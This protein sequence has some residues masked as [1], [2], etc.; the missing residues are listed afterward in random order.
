MSNLT[1]TTT[2]TTPT[3]TA[4]LSELL[5]GLY[6]VP[7][8]EGK[9]LNAKL[10]IEKAFELARATAQDHVGQR[11]AVKA[12]DILMSRVHAKRNAAAQNPGPATNEEE[13]E[14]PVGIITRMIRRFTTQDVLRKQSNQREFLQESEVDSDDNEQQ[15]STQ[16]EQEQQQDVELTTSNTDQ[17]LEELDEETQFEEKLKQQQQSYYGT[18]QSYST[19]TLPTG[20]STDSNSPTTPLLPG[21]TNTTL[22]KNPINLNDDDDNNNKGKESP[23]ITHSNNNNDNDNPPF[24]TGTS[25]TTTKPTT[26]SAFRNSN[27]VHTFILPFSEKR[28][29]EIWQQEL[30]RVNKEYY[31]ELGKLLKRI[32]VVERRPLEPHITPTA[33]QEQTR[34]L[35][36]ELMDIYHELSRMSQFI[37]ANESLAHRLCTHESIVQ[38]KFGPRLRQQL[39]HQTNQIL[40]HEEQEH[41]TH[42][43]KIFSNRLGVSLETAKFELRRH[44]QLEE[45]EYIDGRSRVARSFALGVTI[46]SAIWSAIILIMLKAH[47]RFQKHG[48]LEIFRGFVILTLFLWSAVIQ[49]AI[50]TTCRVNFVFLFQFDDSS[51]RFLRVPLLLSIA[52][53]MTLLVI[54]SIFFS[55]M[56]LGHHEKNKLQQQQQ[57]QGIGGGQIAEINGG[58]VPILVGLVI[59]FLFASFG[60]LAMAFPAWKHIV[61]KTDKTVALQYLMGIAPPSFAA[62]YSA[63]IFTSMSKVLA[64]I[65]RG[66]CFLATP[67]D[68]NLSPNQRRC[69]NSPILHY[70]IVFL[71]LWPLWLRLV[72]NFLQ[73]VNT[74]KRFP[75]FYNMCKYIFAHQVVLFTVFRPDLVSE[76]QLSSW[77]YMFFATNSIACWMWDVWVDFGLG[78]WN[79]SG[80]RDRRMYP[81]TKFYYLA[82]VLDFVLRFSWTLSLMS[83][84][85]YSNSGTF[86][87]GVLSPL[88]LIE[89]VRRTIWCLIRVE[90]EHLN[91]TIGYRELEFVPLY[92]DE[93]FVARDKE[94]DLKP[95]NKPPGWGI[96]MYTRLLVLFFVVGILVLIT[97]EVDVGWLEGKY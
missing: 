9:Y 86:V 74:G 46:S 39:L 29:R 38:Y 69:T 70:I 1:T 41:I 92:F 64:D 21:T 96:L 63:D 84:S 65:A 66:L 85:S 27:L 44:A 10:L 30:L 15:P 71:A 77:F 2:T 80:L 42:I 32:F 61:V 83:T 56:L 17:I 49:I 14:E 91:N 76:D 72:Q 50:F 18:M 87:S 37:S 62:A 97:V 53:A 51:R 20:H 5:A 81:W 23:T 68:W 22:Q 4:D 34:K 95:H 75:F 59:F 90:N 48:L 55:F 35:Q 54:L 12:K 19:T 11:G 13:K 26:T 28:F 16:Q 94:Q 52:T 7:P 88:Q 43:E 33:R 25:T 89:V 57:Q 78:R 6:E 82:I 47:L 8:F 45:S 60:I 93:E 3:I 73:F 36:Q 40:K 58:E 24:T 67:M 79:Y 31:K